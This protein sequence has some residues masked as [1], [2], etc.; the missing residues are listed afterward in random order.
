MGSLR[1]PEAEERYQKAKEGGILNNGCRLCELEGSRTFTHWKIVPNDFP[2]DRIAHRHDMIV[3]RRHTQEP[4]LLE[5]ERTELEMIK[6]E[7][8]D[9]TYEWIMEPTFHQ[10]SV[11]G[12]F[13]LHLLVT[14]DW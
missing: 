7:Y 13:H 11:P 1:T 6:R 14:K 8:I 12:H 2:Y 3:S 9:T 4:N 5:E 10:K